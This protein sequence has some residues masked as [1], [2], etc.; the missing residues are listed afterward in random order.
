MRRSGERFSERLL[1]EL[2]SLRRQEIIDAETEDR[3]RAYYAER[4]AR[5]SAAAAL[6][7]LVSVLAALL[8]VGGTIL[9]IGYNWAAIPKSGKTVLVVLLTLVPMLLSLHLLFIRKKPPSRG[10]KESLALFWAVA[11]G[12]TVA[13]IGQIHQIP[14]DP[15]SFL[16]VWSL[17]TLG[18]VYL[19]DSLAAAA[20]YL[21]LGISLAASM[22]LDGGVGLAFPLL[23]AALLP[24]A[25]TVLRS[26]S[27]ERAAAIRY[28]LT[29]G[30][31]AGLGVSFEKNLPGLW[32][33]A[34]ASL[35][36]IFSL[37]GSMPA[38]REVPAGDRP[39][40][41]GSPFFPA[42]VL[43]TGALAFL[44]SWEWPWEEIGWAAYRTG[45][46]FHDPASIFDY[47]LTAGLLVGA[48][49]LFAIAHSRRNVPN[50]PLVLF[51]PIMAVLY[52]FTAATGLSMIAPWLVNLFIVSLCAAGCYRGF[53]DGSLLSVNASMLF[54]TLTIVSRF[55][56]EDM[57]LLWRGVVFL[58]C[59]LLLVLVN[60]FLV[61]YLARRGPAE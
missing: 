46:R 53:R 3:L 57:S 24:Y 31:V 28:L 15:E 21:V 18:I 8:L 39:Q 56:D 25:S 35:F 55:F 1:D 47:T 12:A 16:L 43:G 26:G 32:L 52:L 2:P 58:A 61:R 22:Q 38:R 45:E 36:S 27:A 14:S 7:T 37:A 44:L 19:L 34:Y 48:A 49:G 5:S 41:A 9:L 4:A 33:V 42:G 50:Y 29:A 54:L 30:A 60:R 20:L 10:R 11:F 40:P 13:A 23:F 59:G 51:G 6:P 17:S